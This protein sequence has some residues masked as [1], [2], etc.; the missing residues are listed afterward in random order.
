M[1]ISGLTIRGGSG[2]AQGG[3][4][5]NSDPAGLTIQDSEI[6]GNAA[7]EGGGV[8]S[9]QPL[10]VQ[11]AR[12][13][14]NEA[15]GAGGGI[16][17]SGRTAKFTSTAVLGNRAGQLGGGLWLQNVE[18]AEITQSLVVGNVAVA[19]GK[20]STPPSGGGI[21]VTT[22][23]RLGITSVQITD[24]TIRGNS[25]A[26]RGGG[27]LWE[28]PGTLSV[29]RSLFAANTAEVGGGIATSSGSANA[30]TAPLVLTN[31]TL[32][33][34]AAEV[35]GGIER[36]FGSTILRGVT[37][38]GNSA[39]TGSGIAFDSARPVYSVAT[40]AIIA[41]TPANRN[42]AR[43][44]GAFAAGESLSAPGTNIE[45][46]TGCHLG[47]P[48]LSSTDPLLGQL[49]DNGG[50]TQTRALRAGS[51][52]LDR[53][54]T[55][56]CPSVDQRGYSRP[57]GSACDIGA[58]EQGATRPK[59]ASD[60]LRISQES[61]GGTLT[62]I[63]RQLFTAASLGG[64]DF[65][66]CTG[67][68]HL[69]EPVAGGYFE[70]GL[71]Q[72]ATRGTL[73]FRR[74]ATRI[75]RLGNLVVLLEGTAGQVLVAVGPTSGALALFDLAGV[76]YGAE[77]AH[78]QLRLTAAGAQ[79]LNRRLGLRG[80]RAGMECG[81]FALRARI[82]LEPFVLK[83]PPPPPPTTTTTT[84]TTTTKTTT[85]TTTAT[86]FTLTATVDPSAGGTVASTPSGIQCL[87][88]CTEKYPTGTSVK[89]T[90]NPVEYKGYSFDEWNAAC[91][92]HVPTCTVKMTQN[93]T[94]TAKFKK[95]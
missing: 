1:T 28:A 67:R 47:T 3:G 61:I 52:A 6:A 16:A 30:A 26:G 63:P 62:L 49:D 32:S 68:R 2:V 78:G 20:A 24:S 86:T 56:G 70:P 91:S 54:T 59:G 75:V 15:S 42:C 95:K 18:S 19:S 27:L 90:A 12:I 93:L 39:T 44:T 25:A 29:E 21:N 43:G 51:P 72:V 66:P 64:R 14:K 11:R 41:N 4:V 57:A 31:T 84:T 37:I 81:R 46:G 71:G 69:N 35:G 94:V 77:T 73:I 79:L 45:S 89:L 92:G 74:D 55:P 82:A 87:P 8:F 38:A 58:F 34:N 65:R 83:P 13:A 10:V 36:S 40:G 85:T 60:L 76:T 7:E 9:S 17:I 48:D 50:P 5:A 23:P 33:G 88:D 53:Y 80:F 22:D